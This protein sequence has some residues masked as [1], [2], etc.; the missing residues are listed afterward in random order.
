MQET[1]SSSTCFPLQKKKDSAE[2]LT[3]CTKSSKSHFNAASAVPRRHPVKAAAAG[4][5]S[6]TLRAAGC[7]GTSDG[8]A[9][10]C[11]TKLSCMWQ[12]GSRMRSVAKSC[13]PNFA[14]S[15]DMLE[16]SQQHTDANETQSRTQP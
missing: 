4:A 15:A 12:F 16:G 11:K 5:P 2:K 6:A 8:S 3:G 9:K 14:Q 1:Y 10:V 7:A 13:D